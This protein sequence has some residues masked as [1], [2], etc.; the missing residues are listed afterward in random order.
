VLVRK[1]SK[2]PCIGGLGKIIQGNLVRKGRGDRDDKGG[3]R[4]H[5]QEIE[6]ED[7]SCVGSKMRVEHNRSEL[8]T[9][10]AAETKKSRKKMGEE[11]FQEKREVNCCERE[12]RGVG[13]REKRARPHSCRERLTGLN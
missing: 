8:S 2:K 10:R 4:T 5:G 12:K 3:E 1:E 6:G 9:M 11:D 7:Y 13:K